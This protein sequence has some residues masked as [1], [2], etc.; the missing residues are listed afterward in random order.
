MEEEKATTAKS[1]RIRFYD[2]EC[3][4]NRDRGIE[5]IA[6][7]FQHRVTG[8]SRERMRGSDRGGL[9]R[10]ARH[11]RGRKNEENEKRDPHAR[12]PCENTGRATIAW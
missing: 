10:A 2:R 1:G 8:G 7:A 11:T 12:K 5:R 4:G 3:C 9:L 6:T